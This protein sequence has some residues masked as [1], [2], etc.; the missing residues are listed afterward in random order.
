[1]TNLRIS[2]HLKQLL[3]QV[4]IMF[5]LRPHVS[6]LLLKIED[7]RLNLN[8]ISYYNH[9]A[10]APSYFIHSSL[11]SYRAFASACTR[12]GLGEDTSVACYE[13]LR[14]IL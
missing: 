6:L 7:E 5:F 14:V 10:G 3:G 13:I 8:V 2:S 11:S 4:A 12:T 9:D 1:M